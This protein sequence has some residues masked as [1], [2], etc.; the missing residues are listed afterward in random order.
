VNKDLSVRQLN[1]FKVGACKLGMRTS[2]D[3]VRTI[4]AFFDNCKLK[5]CEYDGKLWE[6]IVMFVLGVLKA[7]MK[8][9]GINFWIV[10]DSGLDIAQIDL[11]INHRPI[12]LKYD[13][14]ALAITAIQD[15]LSCS[16][17]T[18]VGAKK[19]DDPIDIF[20]DIL[21]AAGLS[22]EEIDREIDINPGFDAACEVWD[23]F[24]GN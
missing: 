19:G 2:S 23:W 15:V 9:R 17:I 6:I 1:A 10:V 16:G 4:G 24:T 18:V 11:E 5:E 13:F 7:S 12:Q 22:E 21:K 14:S 8:E 3:Y 20:R